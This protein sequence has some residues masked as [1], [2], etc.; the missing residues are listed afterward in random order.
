MNTLETN[1]KRASVKKKKKEH[2]RKEIEDIKRNQ[3][4]ILELRNTVTKILK[5]SGW[6]Q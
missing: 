5:L 4:K 6:A 2:F 3:M 1:E